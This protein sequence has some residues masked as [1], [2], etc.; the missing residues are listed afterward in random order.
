M[1][2]D[3]LSI[4]GF[5]YEMTTFGFIKRKAINSLFCNLKLSKSSMYI[6]CQENAVMPLLHGTLQLKLPEN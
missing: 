6:C 5:I 3:L 2:K 4:L 1:F